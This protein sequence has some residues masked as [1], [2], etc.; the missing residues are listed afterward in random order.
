MA[1]CV[2]VIVSDFGESGTW[3]I[4][5]KTGILFSVGNHVDLSKK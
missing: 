1:C 3:V 4:P 2:P 5:G